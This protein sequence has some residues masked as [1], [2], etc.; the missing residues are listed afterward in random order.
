MGSKRINKEQQKEVYKGNRKSPYPPKKRKRRSSVKKKQL[1][2]SKKN[3]R[4]E[5]NKRA[6]RA[7]YLET[8]AFL[9]FAIL[10]INFILNY[11]AH[12]VDGHSMNPTFQ[13]GDRLLIHKSKKVER[14]DIVTFEPKDEP[15]ESYV[16]RVIGL[17]GDRI[18]V[19]N[20]RLYL[21]EHLDKNVDLSRWIDAG[22]LPDSTVVV[23]I[24][25]ESILHL[26]SNVEEIPKDHYFVLGDNRS[27]SKDSRSIGFVSNDQIEGVV[28][29]R[30]YPFNRFGFVH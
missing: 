2:R 4:M 9:I 11:R 20:D 5:K 24:A 15:G 25:Q 27:N 28:T 16:K 13:N 6:K 7:N 14:Y 10:C 26:L 1:Q 23:R 30:F 17:P 19:K 29:F 22:V 18:V 3:K 8:I 21:V 12:F